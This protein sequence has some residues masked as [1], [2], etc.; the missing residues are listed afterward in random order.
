MDGEIHTFHILWSI[1]YD[2]NLMEKEHPC[3]GK[4]MSTN[5]RG[6]PHMMGFVRFSCQPISQAFPIRWVLL[7]FPIFFGSW[8]E[9][10]C[11]PHMIK[12]TLGYENIM[13]KSTHFMT[14]VWEPI[15]QTFPIQWILLSFPM[16]FEIDEKTHAFPMW[17]NIP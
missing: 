11:I 4:S 17:C 3:Y 10:P 12:Y 2:V 16:L 1:P 14:K 7:P 6:S 15:F 8:W 13:E 5:F 9:N